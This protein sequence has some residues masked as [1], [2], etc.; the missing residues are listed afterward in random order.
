[1]SHDN[2]LI[3]LDPT[4]YPLLNALTVVYCSVVFWP[5]PDQ[6]RRGLVAVPWPGSL[7]QGAK[8]STAKK[9]KNV[10]KLLHIFSFHKK[11]EKKTVPGL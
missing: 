10:V 1:M 3:F 11:E 8:R 2:G 5:D 9:P 6:A 7:R 4:P